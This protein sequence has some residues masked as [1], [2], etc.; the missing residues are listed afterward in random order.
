MTTREEQRDGD[1]VLTEVSHGDGIVELRLERAP[2]NALNP[3][4]LSG[5]QARFQ[6]LGADADVR[7]IVISSA[8]KVYSAGMDLREAKDFDLDQQ[9]AVVKGLNEGFLALYACPKPVVAAVNGAA[10]AGGLFF[11]LAAD[12]RVSGPRGSFGLAEVRVGADFPVGPMEIAR[13]SLSSTMLR[14]LMLPG[15]PVDAEAA[16]AG[17]IVDELCDAGAEFDTALAAARR[18]GANPPQAYGAIKRQIRGATID[19]I[20]TAIA[21]GANAPKGGWFSE[22]TRPA[23]IRMLE[24]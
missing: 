23:M 11:V 8:F 21:H 2:V 4:F 5:I 17:G 1:D 20:K 3:D 24:G 13:E 14:R 22:E 6:K 9:H 18:L 12:W 15:Y 10:I 19:R 7:A 16:L